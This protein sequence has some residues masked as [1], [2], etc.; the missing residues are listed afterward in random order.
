MKIGLLYKIIESIDP[1]GHVHIERVDNHRLYFEEVQS[2]EVIELDDGTV[3]ILLKARNPLAKPPISQD[4][5]R[6]L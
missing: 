1:R 6:R 4:V 2:I 3:D 5:P